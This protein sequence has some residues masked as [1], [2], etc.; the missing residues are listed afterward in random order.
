MAGQGARRKVTPGPAAPTASPRTRGVVVCWGIGNLHIVG[1][2][3]PTTVQWKWFWGRGVLRA[4]M[5][6]VLGGPE[7]GVR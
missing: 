2:F 4:V 3:C 6:K 7:V 5:D 1:R